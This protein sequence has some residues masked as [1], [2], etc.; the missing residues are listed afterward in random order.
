MYR[1]CAV[2]A[3]AS[4]HAAAQEKPLTPYGIAAE[5]PILYIYPQSYFTMKSGLEYMKSVTHEELLAALLFNGE[6]NPGSVVQIRLK[7]KQTVTALAHLE[8]DV[9]RL[10]IDELNQK[11][12]PIRFSEVT[13]DSVKMKLLETREFLEKAGVLKFKIADPFRGSK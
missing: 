7:F 11:D 5:D 9:S 13:A 1:F 4:L 10:T 8:T 3:L 12:A 2:L 6:S